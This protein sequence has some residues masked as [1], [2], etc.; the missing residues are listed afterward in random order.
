MIVKQIACEG[1][2]SNNPDHSQYI[3]T[4]NDLDSDLI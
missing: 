1:T 3:A 4:V 2:S